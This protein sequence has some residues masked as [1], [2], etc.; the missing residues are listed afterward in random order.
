MRTSKAGELH[1]TCAPAVG[2]PDPLG[3]RLES[4][5]YMRAFEISIPGEGLTFFPG[6]NLL[7][8]KT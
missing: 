6:P 8:R 1:A 3:S 5:H 7:C 4:W 2:A